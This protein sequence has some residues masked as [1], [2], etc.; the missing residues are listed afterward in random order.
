MYTPA[1]HNH[2]SKKRL[3]LLLK[4]LVSVSENQPRNFSAPR[5]TFAAA[6]KPAN[7]TTEAQNGHPNGKSTRYPA[8][9]YTH[10]ASIGTFRWTQYTPNPKKAQ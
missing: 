4:R 2:N 3:G 5:V 7:A 9:P 1:L 10:G 8:A 6:L